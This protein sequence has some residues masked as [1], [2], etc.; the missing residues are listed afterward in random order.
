MAMDAVE[1]ERMI[2]EALPDARITIE[3]LRGDGD[4][5]AAHVVSAAFKD[6]SRVQQ[7]QM[8]YKALRGKMGD[9]LHALALQTSVPS[10]A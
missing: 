7:H 2:Q 6:K 4:H 5:Y 1:I 8:V 10:E 3:D 9:D